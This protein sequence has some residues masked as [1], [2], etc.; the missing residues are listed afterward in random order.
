MTQASKNLLKKLIP[1]ALRVSAANYV[2]QRNSLKPIAP[3]ECPL[4][5]YRGWFDRFG[6]P[7]RL[8]ARCPRCGS[9]ERHRLLYLA[10]LREEIGEEVDREADRVLHF[11]A[12]P[13]LERIFRK[14][15]RNY[16]TADLFEK[17]DLKINLEAI[18]LPAGAYRLIIANHV[19]EH[20]DDVTA[21]SEIARILSDDGI[22]VA[23]VPIVEGWD[24]TY[25][26]NKIADEAGRW[27]HFGQ[28]DHVRFY[29]RDF[30][31]RMERG[32]LKLRREITATEP[33]VANYGLLRGEKVFVF[34]K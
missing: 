30:R 17:A 19:L 33:D 23:M 22:L 18:D 3:R 14:Q 9:L 13:Q 2:A 4:C 31:D 29:G 27:L 28:G 32:G 12:E 34:G 10:M 21:A 8:D 16:N 7:P 20:V 15:F 26:N 25:E 5:D 6:R 1:R 11:A 24:E